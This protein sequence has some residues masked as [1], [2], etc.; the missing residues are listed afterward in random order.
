MPK[1]IHRREA[2][3]LIELLREYRLAAG[4]TQTELSARLGRAQSFVS[5]VERGQR[6]LDLVQ[7]RDVS[8][9]LGLALPD[10]VREFDRRVEQS[11]RPPRR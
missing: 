7:L 5:D 6:R 3:I 11:E 4:V 1:S 10:L 8:T 2:Q 9:A